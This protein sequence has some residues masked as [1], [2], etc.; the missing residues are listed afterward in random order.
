MLP[1]AAFSYVRC[2][3]L[4]ILTELLLKRRLKVAMGLASAPVARVSSKFQ[5]GISI[6]VLIELLL[7]D[8]LARSSRFTF[9]SCNSDHK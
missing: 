1:L 6:A 7:K 3:M 9:S 5:P 8:E 4:S 2:K